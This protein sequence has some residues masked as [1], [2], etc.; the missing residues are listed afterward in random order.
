MHMALES[1]IIT[2]Y[3]VQMMQCKEINV[4]VGKHERLNARLVHN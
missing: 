3:F 2:L 1:Y 4:S